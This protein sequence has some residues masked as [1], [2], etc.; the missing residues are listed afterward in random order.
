LKVIAV[1]FT[2]EETTMVG[3]QAACGRVAYEEKAIDAEEAIS[4]KRDRS[5]HGMWTDVERRVQT[6][7]V[8]GERPKNVASI[9]EYVDS[10]IVSSVEVYV[11]RHVEFVD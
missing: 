1:R 10:N 7:D 2:K 5:N 11:L 8:V 9:G 6:D 3:F 4:H